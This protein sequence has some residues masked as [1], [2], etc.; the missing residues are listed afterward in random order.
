MLSSR[1]EGL[2]IVVQEAMDAGLPIVATNE[3]GQVDLIQEG[4]NG[5]LVKPEEPRAL[6]DAVCQM[7]DNPALADSMSRNNL[8]TSKSTT[9]TRNLS[10]ISIYSI[11]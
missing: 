10:C 6:A 9:W 5:I 2:G 3:G 8:A 7:R 4:R 11:G 1:H